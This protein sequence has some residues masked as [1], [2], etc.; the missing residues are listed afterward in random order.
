[1]LLKWNFLTL[2]F[3]A[4]KQF[5]S[6]QWFQV[7]SVPSYYCNLLP[8]KNLK[9]PNTNLWKIVWTLNSR[10]QWQLKTL[11]GFT[12]IP[13][14]AFCLKDVFL[15]CGNRP[16]PFVPIHKWLCQDLTTFCIFA[17]QLGLTLLLGK[18]DKTNQQRSHLFSDP[19][20]VE[21]LINHQ[22][23][24]AGRTWWYSMVIIF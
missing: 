23:A 3:S 19:R 24:Y 8:L 9:H 21:L 12:C 17:L 4:D 5:Q 14:L 15:Y 1:M 13:G 16:Q 10:N 18:V 2:V 6:I 7:I 11:T 22:R 20:S